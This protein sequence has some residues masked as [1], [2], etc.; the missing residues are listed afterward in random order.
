[1]K[2]IVIGLGSMGKR[3]IRLLKERKD[4]E[5]FGI[6]TQMERVK[7]VTEDLGVS[8]YNDLQ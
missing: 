2:V 5:I 8:C 1:M 7:Q 4:V 3:R 6:D